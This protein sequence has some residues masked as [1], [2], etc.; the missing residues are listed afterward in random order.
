FV[1]PAV[2]ASWPWWAALVPVS[3]PN[4]LVGPAWTLSYEVMFYLAFGA[5]LLG[6][7]R[8]AVAALCGWAVVVVLRMA[9]PEP[10]T[11]TGQLVVSPFV[12]EFLGGCGVAWLTGRGVRAGWRAAL[13]LAA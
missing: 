10:A 5:L 4:A 3:V 13:V 7:P 1:N 6:P 8:W 11:L 12:L 2:R 9:G